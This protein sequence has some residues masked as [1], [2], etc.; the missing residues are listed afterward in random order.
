MLFVPIDPNFDYNEIH[1]KLGDQ[2][3]DG[4]LLTHA[5]SD[6]TSLIQ[7][8]DVPIYVHSDDAALLF[9]D[10][11]NGYSKDLFT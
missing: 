1:L 11:Y 7:Q 10:K 2:I 8:F 4:I 9:E 6:H 5:H 3:L